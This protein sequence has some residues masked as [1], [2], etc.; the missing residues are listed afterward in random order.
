MQSQFRVLL[1]EDDYMTRQLL[2]TALQR[3]NLDVDVAESAWEAKRLI[4]RYANQYCCILLDLVLPDGDGADIASHVRQT[5]PQIP[6]LAVTG[7]ATESTVA[8]FGDVV[9][10]VIRKPVDVATLSDLILAL[11]NAKIPIR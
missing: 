11:G 8:E 7:G 6:V 1:V 2:A 3:G 10:L 4:S 5:A 9:R